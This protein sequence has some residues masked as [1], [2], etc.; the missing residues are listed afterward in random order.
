M[1]LPR[2]WLSRNVRMTPSFR[3]RGLTASFT[4]MT[5]TY[6]QG[7]LT[8]RT[9]DEIKLLN[10]VPQTRYRTQISSLTE[11]SLFTQ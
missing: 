9:V 7:G 4:M 1:V 5:A 3:C 10:R 6:R 2:L 11:L 8:R